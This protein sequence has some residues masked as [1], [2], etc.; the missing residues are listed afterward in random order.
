MKETILKYGKKYWWILL[1]L[2]LPFFIFEKAKKQEPIFIEEKQEIKMLK[3]DIKGAVKTPGLY[4]MEEGKRVED[5]IQVAGGLTSEADSSMI[6]LSKVL[7]DEMVILIYTK[8]EIR[9]MKEG[10]YEGVAMQQECHCPAITNDGCINK[11]E[12]ETNISSTAK[13]ISINTA[14]LSELMNIPG[15]GKVKAESIIQYRKENGL[16]QK[17]EDIQKVKG[18]GAQ[19]YEKIKGDITL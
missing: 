18:I 14:S 12:A 2:L 13:K 8:E 16:F 6:H 1:F 9:K 10:T 4:E 5:V 15:I 11:E 7:T 17:I 3:V 19:T